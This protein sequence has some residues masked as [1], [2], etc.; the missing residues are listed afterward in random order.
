MLAP[1]LTTRLESQLDALPRL[2]GDASAEVIGAR[3]AS[4]K[5]S[6]RENLAHLARHHE[7]MLERIERI[8][9]E[10]R[11]LL[12]RYRAE[13]DPEWPAWADL[14]TEEVL[15]PLKA[16][17]SRLVER[18]EGLSAAELSRT[19]V[20]PAFGEMTIPAWLEFFLLHEAHHLYVVMTRIG[21]ARGQ[22]R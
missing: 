16:L 20:H 3:P 5:W 21:E 7:V 8:L 4:G 14:S 10:D 19:G 1:F 22:P 9:A 17:R 2:L 18:V 12:G 15:G 11:P 6:A 13:E